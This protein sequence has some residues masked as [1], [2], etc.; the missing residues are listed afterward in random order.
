MGGNV[1]SFFPLS[2]LDSL[3][4]DETQQNTTDSTNI[5]DA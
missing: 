1:F 3:Q 5:H 4:Q 2:P